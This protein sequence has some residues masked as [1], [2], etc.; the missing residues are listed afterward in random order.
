LLFCLTVKLD[1]KLNAMILIAT[2]SEYPHPTPNL[3]A[4]LN[5]LRSMGVEAA[6]RPW[7]TTPLET[8]ATA[9][10][11]LPLCCWDYYDDPQRFLDWIDALEVKGT[12]LLNAPELL[13][14]NFRKTYLLEMAAA[15]LAV[16][17]TIHLPEASHAAIERAMEQEGWSIDQPRACRLQVIDP[18]EKPFR[19]VVI[20]PAAQG[21]QGL[22]RREGLDRRRLP[23]QMRRLQS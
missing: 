1:L 14:W 11:V 4:L 19:I 9:D 5:A 2:C 16:P 6:H 13:R 17:R 20:V 18:P 22:G 21:Q 12:R 10:A 15:G 3:E 8:F 23:G 7:K